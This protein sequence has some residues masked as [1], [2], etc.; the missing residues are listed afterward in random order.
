MLLK[1]TRHGT[2]PWFVSDEP[3][4]PAT[5]GHR[6]NTATR[7]G[8]NPI[9]AVFTSQSA[10]NY[11]PVATLAVVMSSLPNFSKPV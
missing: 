9:A 3:Q 11:R 4:C 5:A 2:S 8:H 1:I 10:F 7:P 6:T